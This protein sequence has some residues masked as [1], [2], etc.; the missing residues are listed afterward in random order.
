MASPLV[1][2]RD[3]RRPVAWTCLAF[4]VGFHSDFDM[5]GLASTSVE[6]AP[7]SSR[8]L[9]AGRHEAEAWAEPGGELVFEDTFDET[10]CTLTAC[11]DGSF[12]AYSSAHGDFLVSD[13]G[14][15]IRCF[16]AEDAEPW[17][18]RR[19]LI[20]QVL[21]LAALLGGLETIHASAVATESGALVIAGRSHVG[22]TS[23][24]VHLVAGGGVLLADDVV[25]LERTGDDALAHPAL[26]L[27]GIRH[28]ECAVMGP[29]RLAELGSV[30]T[31]NDK[32]Q[33]VAVARVG[34][35]QPVRSVYLP[36]RNGSDRGVEFVPCDDPRFLLSATY[37]NVLGRPD[38]L[39]TMLD[40]YAA[41]SRSAGVHRVLV[42][43]DVGA[44]ELAEAIADHHAAS[45]W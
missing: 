3:D 27:V 11:F 16:V 20:G 35:A 9:C 2:V 13:D 28:A 32:E 6:G 44:R 19:F 24:A 31:T 39:A 18:W 38:R 1:D 30:V 15:E 43:S 12:R 42:P 33:L 23:L 25:A 26:G 8:I 22:K 5:P 29:E 45:R 4:G 40:A 37:N 7:R 14:R 21:P 34:A 41:V 10:V 17:K 36:E